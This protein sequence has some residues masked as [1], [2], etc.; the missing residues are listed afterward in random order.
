[1]STAAC[2]S[3]ITYIDG[4]KG[5][6][7]YRGYPIEQL[8]VQCDF[9]E[10]CY[11]LLQGELPD[12]TQKA[13]FVEQRHAA[14]DG[15]RADEPVFSRL[16]PRLASDGDA[17][18]CRRLAVRVL[19]RFARHHRRAPSACLG[20]T[21]DRQAADAGGHVLQVHDGAAVRVPAQR[22]RL[23]GQ[24]HAHDV[25]GT[26]RGLQDQRRAGPRARPH[27]HPAR[28]SRTERVDVDRAAFRIV[29]R[30]SR[31]RASRQA[32]RACGARRTAARTRRR[33][34]CSRKSATSPRSPISSSG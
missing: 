15:A 9:L 20:D 25:L 13:D 32:S 21:P 11:L 16:P 5:E 19:P 26:V 3:K 31:S 24:L 2:V 10:V 18:R 22:A 1:M 6:L 33:S 14:H 28:R 17:R 30:Q 8:A 27:F 12:A 34:T 4:D 23:H 29:R 7:L